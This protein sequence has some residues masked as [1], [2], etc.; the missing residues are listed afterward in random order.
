MK[1][2]VASL[3][4]VLAACVSQTPSPTP[5]VAPA[6]AAPAAQPQPSTDAAPD[7]FGDSPASAVPVPADA[8]E[9]G[10]PFENDWIYD[11]IGRFRRLSH[12]IGTLEGRRY[13]VIE[14]E[15][16]A[17]DRHKYFFDITENWNHWQPP[18]P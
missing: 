3:A 4:L 7:Q 2:R 17:G 13:D 8:A 18:Q 1:V 6:P 9:G 10:V 5:A 12:G 15:T 14:V 16:P 11:R